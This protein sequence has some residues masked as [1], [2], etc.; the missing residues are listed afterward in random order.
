MA[1]MSYCRFQNTLKDLREC[2]DA[3]Q[4]EDGEDLSAE[5]RE[6]RD[7]MI[8]LCGTIH[9]SVGDFINQDACPDCGEIGSHFPSCHQLTDSAPDPYDAADLKAEQQR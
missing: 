5:E 3:I 7:A 4:A 1:N 8:A 6:A 2:W 9:T